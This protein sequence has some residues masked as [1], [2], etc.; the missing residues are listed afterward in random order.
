MDRPKE[1]YEFSHLNSK[2]GKY[3]NYLLIGMTALTILTYIT[4]LVMNGLSAQEDN[5]SI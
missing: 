5:G 2:N 3:H 4:T 1:R